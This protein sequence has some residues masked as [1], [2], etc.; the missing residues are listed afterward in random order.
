MD[1]KRFFRG[2]TVAILIVI[3]LFIGIY[4]FAGSGQT[5]QPQSTSYV[6]GLI[7]NKQVKSVVLTEN[8][9]DNH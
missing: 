9:P 3:A 2:W 6:V 8:D 4:R 1:L 5:Y 7:Q